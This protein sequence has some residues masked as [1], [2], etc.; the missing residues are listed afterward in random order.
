MRTAMQLCLPLLV[1]A[2]GALGCSEEPEQAAPVEEAAIEEVTID[3]AAALFEAGDAVAID[4]NGAQTRAE[5][6]V[7]PGATLL[8]SSGSYD[9]DA[10]LPA[11]ASATL[12]FYCGNTDCHASD[13]AAER[14]RQAGRAN[15]RVMR[16][17]IAGWVASGRETAQPQS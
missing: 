16:E 14:A 3:Q 5:H 10:E 12:V 1:L 13:G 4:A 15:V 2:F 8:T 7:V 11:D 6:G 17:G 9:V